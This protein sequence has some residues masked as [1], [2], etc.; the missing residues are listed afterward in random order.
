MEFVSDSSEKTA[1]LALDF[2][3]KLPPSQG[4]AMVVGLSGD[5]GSGKTTFSQAVGRHLGISEIMTS[6][7]FVIQ[8]T[9]LLSPQNFS[10][11]LAPTAI[12]KIKKLIHIDAYRLESG[13][14]LQVLGFEKLLR[15]PANLIL[16]EWPEKVSDILPAEIVKVNF[17]FI[18]ETQRE[19]IY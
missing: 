4:K 3:A 5:L 18:T 2:L 10:K 1:D 17:K 19:I 12:S 13:R 7:T 8:K 9:Y 6:P 14:E 15:D 16:I 11:K